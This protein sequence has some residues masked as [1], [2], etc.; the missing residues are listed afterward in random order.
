MALYLEDLDVLIDSAILYI[1]YII[2]YYAKLLLL[3]DTS[4]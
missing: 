3:V 2:V 1:L 4:Y